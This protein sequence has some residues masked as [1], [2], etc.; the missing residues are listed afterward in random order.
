M[1]DSPQPTPAFI[2]A[3]STNRRLQEFRDAARIMGL[4]VEP[5]GIGGALALEITLI[6]RLWLT[7][8][9]LETRGPVA[10]LAAYVRRRLL[11]QALDL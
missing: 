8:I 2:E 4:H 10:D 1:S 5:K 11:R 7:P 9:E 6:P 3:T